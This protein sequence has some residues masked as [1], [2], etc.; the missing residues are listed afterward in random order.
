MKKK[1]R[2]FVATS[3]IYSFFLVFLAVLAGLI[4]NYVA[5]KL[6]LERFNENAASVLNTNKY[7]ITIVSNNSEIKRGHSITNLVQNG[8]F[9]EEIA[10]WWTSVG[11]IAAIKDGLSK[12][13][14][15]TNGNPS[16]YIFQNVPILEG[17]T[18]YMSVE[19]AKSFED[20][21][22]VEVNNG[23]LE[24][25][26][27]EGMKRVSSNFV[28][29]DSRELTPFKI[30]Q[31]VEPYM[32]SV[33]ITNIMLINLTDHYEKGDVPTAEWLDEFIDYFD[34]TISY[35]VE[36]HYGEDE[37]EVDVAGSQDYVKAFLTCES[38]HGNWMDINNKELETTLDEESGR[39]VATVKLEDITDDI[40]CNVR[41]SK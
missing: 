35:I 34:G 8:N 13:L 33:Y 6:V 5:N 23:R 25:G 15:M 38:Q 30:G 26:K 31:S 14:N 2:G 21:V 29:E 41:W 10:D 16:S 28:A 22:V 7:R 17:R 36:N 37:Y 12:R 18:Y 39:Y 40:K 24:L 4:R 20:E 11:E 32:D 27:Q 19:Y 9:D 3:L 1:K